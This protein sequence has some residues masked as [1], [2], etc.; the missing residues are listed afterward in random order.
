MKKIQFECSKETTRN[1]YFDV[2]WGSDINSYIEGADDYATI[3]VRADSEKE[4]RIIFKKFIE[5]IKKRK[6]RLIN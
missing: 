2:T 1:F 4:A 6:T 5:A 3:K